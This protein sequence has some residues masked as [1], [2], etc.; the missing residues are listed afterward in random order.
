ML[1]AALPFLGAGTIASAAAIT[2]T[3]SCSDAPSLPGATS[4]NGPHQTSATASASLTSV[5]SA[6]SYSGGGTIA[7][8]VATAKAEVNVDYLLTVHGGSGAGLFAVCLT[9]FGTD[10]GSSGSGSASAAFGALGAFGS[11]GNTGTA[12]CDPIVL[13]HIQTGATFQYDV[14]QLLH[15]RLF[16]SSYGDSTQSS[17]GGSSNASIGSTFTFADSAHLINHGATFT[18]AEVPEPSTLLLTFIVLAV[19]GISRN[20]KLR[21][22]LLRH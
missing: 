16:S 18:L 7:N 5:S 4:C 1:F 10:S 19:A 13:D 20:R 22:H 17:G 14:P 3:V 12:G 6:A 11:S 8:Y 15:L 21:G 2:I 9:A